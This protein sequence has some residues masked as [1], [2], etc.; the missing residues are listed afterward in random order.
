MYDCQRWHRSNG[1][2][3]QRKQSIKA[4]Y[5][6]V[7]CH[8]RNCP[9]IAT[10]ANS[11][12]QGDNLDLNTVLSGKDTVTLQEHEAVQSL[13]KTANLLTC[14]LHGEESLRNKPGLC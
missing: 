10:A 2:P 12:I 1:K 11:K 13:N 9:Q 5:W 3:P 8:L 7:H 6:D 4:K 14:S